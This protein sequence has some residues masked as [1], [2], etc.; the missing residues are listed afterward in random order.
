MKVNAGSN[1]KF[2]SSCM[3]YRPF[4]CNSK[5]SFV[6]GGYFRAAE[7]RQMVGT[8]DGSPDPALNVSISACLS[9]TATASAPPFVF[10]PLASNI[11][12]G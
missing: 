8:A 4:S 10:A 11:A 3:I 5:L 6:P 1:P 7:I 9:A 2:L 12:C